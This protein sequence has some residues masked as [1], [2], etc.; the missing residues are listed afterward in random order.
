MARDLQD[1]DVDPL[2][3]DAMRERVVVPK[4]MPYG[5]RKAGPGRPKGHPKTGGR[6][7]GTPNL[8][9]P[10]YREYI[11]KKGKPI[12]FLADMCAGKE[13]YDGDIK[14]KPSAAERIRA[15]ETLSRKITPDLMA[16]QVS[17]LVQEDRVKTMS[18]AEA[19]MRIAFL[20]ARGASDLEQTSESRVLAKTV[21]APDA[22]VIEDAPKAS[23]ESELDSRVGCA[24][25]G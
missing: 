20:L 19:A 5:N 15:A 17:A 14:R 25:G 23:A 22:E 16:S 24:L 1:D 2:L 11:A 10:E 13:F 4:P 6:R 9:S 8:W 3:V 18:D 21:M 12:E 7:A